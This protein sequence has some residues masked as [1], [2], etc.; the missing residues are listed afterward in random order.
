VSDADV[1]IANG[2]SVV[3]LTGIGIIWTFFIKSGNALRNQ[4]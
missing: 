2:R 1:S 3:F 4:L